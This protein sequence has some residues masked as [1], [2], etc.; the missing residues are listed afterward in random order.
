M[1][2]VS[3]FVFDIC[4]GIQY[5]NCVPNINFLVICVSGGVGKESK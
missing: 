3:A 2:S 4:V 5:E 1:L